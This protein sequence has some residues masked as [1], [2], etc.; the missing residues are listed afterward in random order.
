MCFE[1]LGFALATVFYDFSKII[2]FIFYYF[3][4]SAGFGNRLLINK[5]FLQQ[6]YLFCI[7]AELLN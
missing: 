6:K 1:I 4:A 7:E 5:A 2:F 3:S